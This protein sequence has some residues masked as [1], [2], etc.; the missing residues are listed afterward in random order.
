LAAGL[1]EVETA[2]LLVVPARAAAD[3]MGLRRLDLVRKVLKALTEVM[4]TQAVSM[5]P[6][7]VVVP[8]VPEA[9]QQRLPP[10]MAGRVSAAT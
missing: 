8:G 9:A 6:E 1:E 2:L 10:E 4:D 5:R 3:H 7:A